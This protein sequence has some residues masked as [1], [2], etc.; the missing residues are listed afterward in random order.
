MIHSFKFFWGRS[1]SFIEIMDEIDSSDEYLPSWSWAEEALHSH[2]DRYVVAT[3]QREGIWDFLMRFP[4]DTVVPV[5][6]IMGPNGI[7]HS[8]GINNNDGWGFDIDEDLITITYYK[9]RETLGEE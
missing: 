5:I 6:S 7:L 8:E 4:H 9:L 3:E 1:R 2:D